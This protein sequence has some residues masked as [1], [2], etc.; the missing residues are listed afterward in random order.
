LEKDRAGIDLK[1]STAI[2]HEMQCRSVL[3]SEGMVFSCETSTI[4]F[5]KQNEPFLNLKIESFRLKAS[6]LKTKSYF[7]HKTNFHEKNNWNT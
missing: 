3:R 2:G 1:R 4:C 5:K 7:Y 6:T